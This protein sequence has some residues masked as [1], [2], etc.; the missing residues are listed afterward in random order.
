MQ[1]FTIVMFHVAFMSLC[2]ILYKLS[3]WRSLFRRLAVNH[4]NWALTLE[5]HSNASVSLQYSI[6]QKSA[7]YFFAIIQLQVTESNAMSFSVWPVWVWQLGTPWPSGRFSC[8][9]AC[10]SKYCWGLRSFSW[11]S[12]ATLC[13]PCSAWPTAQWQ[14]GHPWYREYSQKKFLLRGARS[15]SPCIVYSV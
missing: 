5:E 6:T 12:R 7:L 1:W 13:C 14:F 15:Y 4:N 8:V 3:A 2:Y 11:P 9:A 10:C